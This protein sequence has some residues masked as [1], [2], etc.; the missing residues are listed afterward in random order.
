MT[1]M[2][3]KRLQLHP[4]G[5]SVR[6]QVKSA[7]VVIDSDAESDGIVDVVDWP[8]RA[9][10]SRLAVTDSQR[11]DFMEVYSPPRIT[12]ECAALGSK[13]ELS[14]DILTG[15]NF[16]KKAHRRKALKLRKKAS[17]SDD[18]FEPTMHNVFSY[19]ADQHT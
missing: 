2:S 19:A 18:L 16:L 17:R 5:Q 8:P 14:L 12:P 15:H 11:H 6:Q 13:A 9:K 10:R 4:Q 3:K 1:A 7:T